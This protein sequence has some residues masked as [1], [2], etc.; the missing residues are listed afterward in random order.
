[1]DDLLFFGCLR[2]AR[3]LWPAHLSERYPPGLIG[4][5]LFM[6]I[7]AGVPILTVILAHVVGWLPVEPDGLD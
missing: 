6:F 7:M 3:R 1:M 4:V 5:L 2:L